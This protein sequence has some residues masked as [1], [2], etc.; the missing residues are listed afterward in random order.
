MLHRPTRIFSLNLLEQFISNGLKH[1]SKLRNY[2][3]GSKD[4]S[5]VSNLSPYIKKR[6]IHEKEILVKCFEKFSYKSIEKF[7]QEIFWR[8][9]WKG[10]LEGRNKIW[11]EYNK[12]LSIIQNKIESSY[13]LKQ[14]TKAINAQTGIE[15]F[16]F[17]VNELIETGY[18]HNHSRM[19]FAS[20]WIFTLN[21]PWQL[22]SDFFYKH[23]LDSDAAS[24]TLSWR[25]VAGLHTQGKIYLAKEANVEKF[26]KFRFENYNTFNKNVTPPSNTQEIY[27]PPIFSDFKIKERDFFL[28]NPNYLS[29]N[30]DFIN[31]IKKVNVIVLNEENNLQEGKIKREFNERAI[32]NYLIFLKEQKINVRTFQN[33]DLLLKFF[34]NENIN[35]LFTVYPGIGYELDNLKKI[36]KT[37][38]LKINFY[39]D[40][41]DIMCWP[42]AKSGFF[43]FKNK[44]NYFIDN[45]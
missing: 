34:K 10:W 22:G 37:T 39:Y 18:L 9:Y 5:N 29:Y 3:Y 24:N 45:L 8:S 4:R 30:E 27:V 2:D 26:S 13:L 28:V 1:Y 40:K 20:I 41:F 6:I 38:K 7:V 42:H 15:C 16:D 31:K 25:W 35:E 12:E 17:W 36:M 33:I 23:L 44:I 32:Y 21:L 11:D 19:W 14:Y 43:K